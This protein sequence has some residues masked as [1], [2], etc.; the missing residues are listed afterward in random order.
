MSLGQELQDVESQMSLYIAFISLEAVIE[1][2]R[3]S[4][5]KLVERIVHVAN[6]IIVG[7]KSEVS[8]EE[9]TEK[10][11]ARV[12][13]IVEEMSVLELFTLLF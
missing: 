11:E 1:E 13:Q 7:L 4:S 12:K 2:A 3:G 6:K 8:S 5:D 10:I 9:S